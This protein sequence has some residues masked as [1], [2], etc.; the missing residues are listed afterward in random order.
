MR[1][2]SR[3]PRGPGDV[4]LVSQLPEYFALFGLA[5]R[6]A[7]DPQRLAAAYREVLVQVHPDRHAASGAAQQRVAMQM[8]SHA[9]E[10][11]R[12]LKSD[13]AR[14]AYLCR[15]HGALAD[16]LE[17]SRRVPAEFLALQ[18]CWRER[19]EDAKDPEARRALRQEVEAAHADLLTRITGEIDERADYAAAADSVRALLFVEKFIEKMAADTAD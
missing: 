10:A 15:M 4:C 13:S 19:W 18:M 5:P 12:I 1:A 16:G 2:G 14:A 11:Y 8:A 17:S 6:F 3:V 7:L 9:N